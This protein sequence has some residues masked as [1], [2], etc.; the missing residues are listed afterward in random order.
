MAISFSVSGSPWTSKVP[1][2]TDHIHADIRILYTYIY[3]HTLSFRYASCHLG[4]FGGPGLHCGARLPLRHVKAV[5]RFRRE[6]RSS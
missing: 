6:I 4:Y 3:M 2:R 1:K 5:A